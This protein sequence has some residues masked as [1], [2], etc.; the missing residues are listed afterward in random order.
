[1]LELH[2]WGPAF[3]LPSIEPQC[4]AAIAYLSQLIPHGEWVLIA[5]CDD[6]LSHTDNGWF[7]SYQS[8]ALPALRNGPTWIGGLPS[9]IEYLGRVP[10]RQWDLDVANFNSRQ[11]A[12]ITAFSSLAITTG[13]SV[14]DL[15]LY[16]SSD[17]YTSAT[18]PALSRQLLWPQQWS[19]PSQKRSTAKARTDH[20]GMSAL[21]LDTFDDAQDKH[22]GTPSGSDIIPESLRISRTSVMELV[23]R[24]QHA[25]RFRLDALAD[26]FLGPL[27]Q[28]LGKKS[29]MLSDDHPSSLDCVALAYLA[30]AY[31]PQLPHAWV[32]EIMTARYP[33]L[34][35]YVDRL[36]MGFFGGPVH[37]SHAFLGSEDVP[38]KADTNPHAGSS[39][40]LPWR[41]PEQKGFTAGGS[42]IFNGTLNALPLVKHFQRRNILLDDQLT[43][44]Q[45][46]GVTYDAT[47][48]QDKIL[49]PL[50]ALGSTTAALG[51]YLFYSSYQI[52]P[53][54]QGNSLSA[55]GEAGAM[56]DTAFGRY[57]SVPNGETQRSGRVPVGLEVDVVVDENK[58]VG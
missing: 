44:D 23:K 8:G 33:E 28:L 41:R 1:M 22:T 38:D 19:I 57:S 17:N 34:C 25:T 6:A 42:A 53:A 47:S 3:S 50:L 18:R 40:I 13:Q 14:L 30:L 9:I 11:R 48:K 35:A 15:S 55:M 51:A 56:L 29:Y 27:Q 46:S 24:P 10:H 54:S 39:M 7:I 26:A 31:T 21:D 52:E 2:V 58:T 32:H 20:L 37:V 5:S 36:S 45:R 12:D 43:K 16:V 49:L 4:L